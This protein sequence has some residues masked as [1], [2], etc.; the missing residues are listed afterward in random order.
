MSNN[1]GVP[2]SFPPQGQQQPSPDQARA[3]IG[4]Q[5]AQVAMGI[6]SRAAAGMLMNLDVPRPTVEQFEELA[7]SSHTAAKAYFSGL[8]IAEFDDE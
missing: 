3:M 2:M 8:G 6:Y 5:I 4:Q 7:R 1:R